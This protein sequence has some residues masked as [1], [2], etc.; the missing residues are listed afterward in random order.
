MYINAW[1]HYPIIFAGFFPC[2]LAASLPFEKS[3]NPSLVVVPGAWHSPHH[4]ILVQK[5][6]ERA[7]Y[8]V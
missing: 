8:P 5:L 7:G 1:L 4:F 2:F 6:L 3:D